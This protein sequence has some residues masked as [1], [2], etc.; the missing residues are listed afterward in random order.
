MRTQNPT[1]AQTDYWLSNTEAALREW[2][3]LD[4]STVDLAA[5]RQGTTSEIEG[6]LPDCGTP[7]CFGGWLPYFPHFKKLGVT[8]DSGGSPQMGFNYGLWVAEGLFGNADMFY[9][10]SRDNPDDHDLEDD[11][12]SMAYAKTSDWGVV[13][14]RLERHAHYL[15]TFVN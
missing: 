2:R 10:R 15:G 5:Y 1:P 13:L 11:I 9:S 8:A 12:G 7:A 4:P 6:T 14:N 3:K